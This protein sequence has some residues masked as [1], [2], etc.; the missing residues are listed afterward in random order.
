VPNMTLDDIVKA[1]KALEK[2]LDEY[3]ADQKKLQ[4]RINKSMG[5]YK[6][7]ASGMDEGRSVIIEKKKELQ[8]AYTTWSKM[9]VKLQGI[10]DAVTTV[11]KEAKATTAGLGKFADEAEKLSK[12]L[13]KCGGD[14]SEL[15][16]ED[17]ALKKVTKYAN[18]LLSDYTNI[19]QQTD[20][21][22]K[23]SAQPP[24]ITA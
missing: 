11:G 18:R 14:V 15:K 24:P 16:E 7:V 13:T 20:G 22:P 10:K 21:L 9:S 17:A 1:R 3:D 23:D 12:A 8:D 4:T 19:I 2:E 6:T 5:E